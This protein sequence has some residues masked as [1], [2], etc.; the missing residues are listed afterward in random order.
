MIHP[1][2]DGAGF[3]AAAIICVQN[4]A[5]MSLP[6]PHFAQYME[7]LKNCLRT[8]LRASLG[9]ITALGLLAGCAVS[10][11]SLPGALTVITMTYN[12][13]CGACEGK[14]DVNHWDKRKHLVAEV[15]RKSDADLIGLQEAEAFQVKDLVDA[16]PAYD[17]YGVGR[18]DGKERGEM[19]A[20]LVRRSAFEIVAPRTLWLSDTPQVVSKGWDAMLNRTVTLVKLKSK[21]TGGVVHLWNT[22]FDHMGDRARQ[23]SARLIVR[24]LQS[25]G[26]GD[27]VILTGDLNLRDTHPAYKLLTAELQDAETTSQ[28]PP[29]GGNITFNGFGR[30][31]QSGNKI[32]F[33]FVSAGQ[34]VRSH[35]V[36][37]EPR[38][39]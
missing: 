3:Q 7:F 32:D 38:N 18:E 33:I 6:H 13:R 35:R 39:S 14:S 9:A 12:I 10:Q 5:D 30:D 16:L 25:Q 29:S 1:A 27:P 36:I 8:S 37:T 2:F 34:T 20:V 11:Q 4:R 17:W 28:T 21:I 23:E 26:A 22:H 15:I 31:L 24:T 19:A